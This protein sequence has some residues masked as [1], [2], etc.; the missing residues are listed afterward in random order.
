MTLS[1]DY[2]GRC[3]NCHAPIA[4][5]DN[6][7]SS[8]GTKAGEGKFEPCAVEYAMVYGPEPPKRREHKCPHC[9]YIWETYEMFDSDTYC[10]KCGGKGEKTFEEDDFN[11]FW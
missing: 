10:V 5:T 11:S 9:S 7:C 2:D 1:T 8:C 6:Y 3:G 4:A